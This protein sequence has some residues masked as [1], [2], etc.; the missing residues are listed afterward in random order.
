GQAA[1]DY[2]GDLA[3]AWDRFWFTPA[4]PTTFCLIRLFAGLMLFYTHLVWTLDLEAFFGRTPWI[5][6]EAWPRA[7]HGALAWSYL[8]YV[9]SPAL[10][11]TLH[12]AALVVLPMFALGLVSRVTSV[13]PFLITVSSPHL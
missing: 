11:W 4:D 13:L 8:L 12:I 6:L 2:L 9:Q 5:S 1:A 7:D 3:R 10:L